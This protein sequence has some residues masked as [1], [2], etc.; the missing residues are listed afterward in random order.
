MAPLAWAMGRLFP[1][2]LSR[3]A[4]TTSWMPWAWAVNGFASV[5]AASAATLSSVHLG[6]PV[7]LALGA[8]CYGGTWLIARRVAAAGRQGI[9]TGVVDSK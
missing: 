5:L 7:T 2:G 8:A 9:T 4:D 6:Q 3:L 1:W